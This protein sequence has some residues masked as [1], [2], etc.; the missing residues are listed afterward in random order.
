MIGAKICEFPL[1]R[2][3]A[4]LARAVN[5]PVIMGAP[6][7]VRGGSQSGNAAAED[8]IEAGYCDVLVS[9]YHYPS[10]V[11][12]VFHLLDQGVRSLPGAWKLVSENPAGIM[13][14]PDRG[15]IEQGRRADLVVV[16]ETT[17]AVEATL[18][19]GRISFMTAG[20]A[21]RFLRARPGM[22]MAAE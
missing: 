13:R 18:V 12:A 8:L 11:L 16:N 9:D 1:T 19:A 22:A 17:R 7:V 4:K 3:A 20:A 21:E 14:L 2:A 6:N 5:D 15:V 10:L